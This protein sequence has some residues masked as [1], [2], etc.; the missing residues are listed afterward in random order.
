MS[1]SLL[2]IL[3]PLHIVANR[4]QEINVKGKSSFEQIT[5][6]MHVFEMKITSLKKS[7]K[8][9]F[10]NTKRI[11][12]TT[13]MIL[14]AIILETFEFTYSLRIVEDYGI[15]VLNIPDLTK[16]N[17][18]NIFALSSIR[19]STN[20]VHAVPLINLI[21]GQGLGITD[22]ILSNNTYAIIAEKH[23]DLYFKN[24]D[25]ISEMSEQTS[26][27]IRFFNFYLKRIIAL[28][29]TLLFILKYLLTKNKRKVN[30]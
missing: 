11:I 25:L 28:V 3:P 17:Y 1:L 30:L 18:L 13:S 29:I 15:S 23:L 6:K 2:I 12:R 4:I 16:V 22:F 9:M 5:D 26:L 24:P 21:P 19:Y 7:F 27:I 8:S 10:K 20:F 14:V